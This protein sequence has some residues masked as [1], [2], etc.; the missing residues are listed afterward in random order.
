MNKHYHIIIAGAGGIAEAV[1][2]I[3]SE[4]SSVTP[5]I[6]IGNRTF[7]K[8]QKVANWIQEGTSKQCTVMPFHLEANTLTEEMKAIFNKADALLDCLPGHLAPKMAQYAKNFELH[9]ANLTE[10][11][12]ETNQIMDIAKNAKTGFVLQTGLAPGYINVLANHLFQK[13]CEIYKVDLVDSLEFKVGALTKHAVAPHYYGFTWSPIGV[14][15][16]YVK[17]AIALRN[18]KK[19]MLPAL[20]EPSIIIIN[21]VTYEDDL[22]SGGAANLPDELEGKV[23][24]L[25]YKTLRHPGHYDWVKAEL[26][27]LKNSPDMIT[28]L[29]NRMMDNIPNIEEDQIVIYAAVQ[30]NDDKCRLRRQE[31]AKVIHPQQVGK[32]MLRAIQT[33]TAVPLI[34]AMQWLLETAPK[35]VILQSDMDPETFLNGDYIVPIYGKI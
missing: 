27:D 9:Y 16:E 7:A 1:G 26:D 18:Y 6:Y 11:V 30:G 28:D 19:V 23:R 17:D 3:L 33:T 31:I 25:D 13:F 24:T 21:G 4:W 32:H 12:A 5:T 22:T 35:G 20:S 2:L 15:T 29:Q 8:A 10:Y 34:Q 14:A